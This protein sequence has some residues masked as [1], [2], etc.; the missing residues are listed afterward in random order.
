MFY[1]LESD[2]G[3]GC[4]TCETV[5]QQPMMTG[6]QPFNP[7]AMNNNQ[8]QHQPPQTP[9]VP[10]VQTPPQQP[11][12]VVV[13]QDGQKVAMD[14]AAHQAATQYTNEPV[15]EAPDF[16]NTVEG[17]ESMGMWTDKRK[18]V[19]CVFVIL[20]ALAINE[21]MK[22]YLNKGVQACEGTSYHYLSYAIL[23]VLAVVVASHFTR[24][25]M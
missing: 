11:Q 20:T 17:F 3:N 14:S 5:P 25:V 23:A 24:H 7:Y 2:Y 19:V 16:M 18:M 10:V 6:Q 15:T 9:T 21:C 22:Y 8:Q 4:D 12:Q 1:N 13:Q